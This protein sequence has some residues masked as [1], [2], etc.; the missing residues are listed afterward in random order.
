MTDHIDQIA[1]NELKM[2]MEN[3]FDLLITTFVTDSLE[4]VATLRLAIAAGDVHAVRAAAHSF[5]GSSLNI[6]AP[7]LSELCRQ[8]EAEGK[9]GQLI[10]AP[11][12]LV[13]IEAEF[14][15]VCTSLRNL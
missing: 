8:L 6:C 4:R 11:D 12:L 14:D 2:I 1:L 9:E 10:S 3:D 15:A 7:L 5:K 13:S